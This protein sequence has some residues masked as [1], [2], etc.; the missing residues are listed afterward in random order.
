[1]DLGGKIIST[2]VNVTVT[3]G[4]ATFT[5]VTTQKAYQFDGEDIHMTRLLT[6]FELT[7]LR[8]YCAQEDFDL[9]N[10]GDCDTDSD[11]SLIL[12]FGIRADE[13]PSLRRAITTAKAI[14]MAH[15]Q[16]SL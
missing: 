13:I 9:T 3:I 1:M 14:T 12:N 10:F 5:V 2:N 16:N 6:L 15:Q 8:Q 7:K 4:G 11:E